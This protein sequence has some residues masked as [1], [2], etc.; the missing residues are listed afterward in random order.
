L[1]KI[2]AMKQPLPGFREF[3]PPECAARNFIFQKFR[4]ISHL[5]GYEEFD[6]PVMEP[7]ELFTDKSGPEIVEQLFSFQDRGGRSVTLRPEMTPILARMVGSRASTLRRPIRWC[8][9]GENFRYERPQKGR[10]RSFY[11]M[12]C[13]LLGES[14]VGAD[15]EVIFLLVRILQAFGLSAED[16]VVRLSDRQIWTLFL[17]P[18]ADSGEKIG[19]VLGAI[20]KIERDPPET[21]L[22]NLRRVLPHSAEEVLEKIHGLRD[23][24]NLDSLEKF[25]SDSPS[26]ALGNRLRQ[27]GILL[28]FLEDARCGDFVS[29]DLGI[30][31]GLA[32]YTGFVFEA[33]ERTGANRALAGGGRYDDLV[34]KLGG[35]DL[36]A[37]GFAIGDVTLTHLLQEKALLPAYENQPHIFLIFDGNSQG[38]ALALCGKLRDRGWV[39]SHDLDPE[40]SFTKQLKQGAKMGARLAIFLGNEEME[41]NIYRIRDLE[42]GENLDCRREELM[43]KL[44]TILGNR[45]D[46]PI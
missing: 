32:Y 25:L 27:W 42:K 9:V 33:F 37:V 14:G 10:L 28:K 44:E 12:N 23:C 40:S 11:Q 2:G 16:F 45:R 15:G 46:R 22:E 24:K 21:V 7:L 5:F 18:F 8:N 29:V 38:E 20:D 6:A 36:P 43:E 31:R 4:Q 39:V 26:E 35:T 30:V 13:D 1:G 17:E 34:G 3:Y 19:A 41:K